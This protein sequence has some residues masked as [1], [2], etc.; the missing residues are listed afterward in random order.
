M[1]DFPLCFRTATIDVIGTAL[2][3]ATFSWLTSAGLANMAADPTT[4]SNNL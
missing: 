2:L 4:S 1:T 3:V